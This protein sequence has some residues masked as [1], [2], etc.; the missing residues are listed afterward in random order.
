MLMVIIF[1]IFV[2]SSGAATQK[3]LDRLTENSTTTY[4]TYLPKYDGYSIQTR[5]RGL[6]PSR[7]NASTLRG[8]KQNTL[9][10]STLVFLRRTTTSTEVAS[11]DDD[12]VTRKLLPGEAYLLLV[13]PLHSA[14]FHILP[15]GNCLFFLLKLHV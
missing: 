10:N 6:N 4:R 7:F 12:D 15:I 8:Q 1:S 2:T 13:P 11:S 14:S 3:S 5:L 9:C